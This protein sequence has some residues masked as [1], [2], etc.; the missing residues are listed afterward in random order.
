ML[1]NLYLPKD[2][3]ESSLYLRTLEILGYYVEPLYKM[4]RQLRAPQL[5]ASL[6]LLLAVRSTVFGGRSDGQGL[7]YRF[8]IG[9]IYLA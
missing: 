1:Y 5:S 2:S 4:I 9:L 3:H 6:R 8:R 7:R